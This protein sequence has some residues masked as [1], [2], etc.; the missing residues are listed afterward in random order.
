MDS[1]TIKNLSDLFKNVSEII[2]TPFNNL[3]NK[4]TETIGEGLAN[5]FYLIFSP[6]EIAK[7]YAS[8]KISQY[9]QDLEDK[10]NRIP[11]DKRVEPPLNIVG[12]AL[13]ASRFYIDDDYLRSMFANLIASSMNLDS[14]DI[15]HPAF[16]EII[17]QLKPLDAQIFLILCSNSDLAV[18]RIVN[19][20]ISLENNTLE[21]NYT[22]LVNN[23]FPL[24]LVNEKNYMKIEAS[25]DNLQ[26]LNLISI[27]YTNPFTEKNCYNAIINHPLYKYFDAKTQKKS[28]TSYIEGAWDITAFGADFAKVCL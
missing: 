18:A 2:K 1:N 5:I 17:K 22:M 23:F 19:R 13:E 6:F 26:R 24:D 10:I 27:N 25:I 11:N 28:K 8:N 12:P 21:N 9:K 20:K 4:P 15:V 14:A 7:I 16:V 3:T